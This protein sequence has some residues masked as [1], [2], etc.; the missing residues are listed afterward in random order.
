MTLIPRTHCLAVGLGLAMVL[1]APAFAQNQPPDCASASVSPTELWPPN[2]K[3]VPLVLSGVADPDGDPVVARVVEVFQDEPVDEVGDGA[4]CPD[5]VVSS[6][7]GAFLRSERS[8]NGDGRVYHVRFTADDGNGGTC[9]GEA[10]VCVPH[11][12]G[13]GSA[14]VDQGPLFDTVSDASCGPDECELDDCIPDEDD[15]A[16]QCDEPLPA[17]VTRR[18]ARARALTI[19]AD[20]AT[21]RRQ[22]RLARKAARLV[23]KAKARIARALPESCS[24]PVGAMLDGA[25]A[26]C[27]CRDPDDSAR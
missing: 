16:S 19:R 23:R 21:G 2:H 25:V 11:D 13:R 22:L 27:E 9:E 18:L 3:L 12:R 1:A 5:G 24:E 26:C 8:G 7:D 17:G 15:V 20:E 10:T 4:T 6:V 14:C